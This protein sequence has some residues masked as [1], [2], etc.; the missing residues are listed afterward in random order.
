MGARETILVAG[1]VLLAAAALLLA[2]CV[3]FGWAD[4]GPLLRENATLG[5]LGVFILVTLFASHLMEGYDLERNTT[6]R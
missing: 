1:D 2:A 4:M 3:R 5:S 6:G